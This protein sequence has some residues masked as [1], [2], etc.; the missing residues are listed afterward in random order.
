VCDDCQIYALLGRELL[1]WGQRPPD[2]SQFPVF[3]R[4]E[5]DGW[6]EQCPWAQL[7]ITPL[8]AGKPDMDKMRFFTS[9]KYKDGGMTAEVH[10]ITKLVARDSRGRAMPPYVNQV[11]LTLKK[12]DGRWILAVREQGPIT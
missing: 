4:P 12:L 3:Y 5:G 1:E 7:G 11:N 9:P 2:I 8:P 6:A 10:F